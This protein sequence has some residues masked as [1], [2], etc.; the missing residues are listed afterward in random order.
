MHDRRHTIPNGDAST[1]LE[2]RRLA[3]DGRCRL[4]EEHRCLLD[5]QPPLSET[6]GLSA[7]WNQT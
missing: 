3:G 4:T 5:Q 6:T 2:A 7:G 1:T